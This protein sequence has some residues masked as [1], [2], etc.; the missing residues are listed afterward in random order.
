MVDPE[1]RHGLKALA[2]QWLGVE[3]T[4]IDAL[5]DKA[6]E[7]A[8]GLAGGFSAWQTDDHRDVAALFL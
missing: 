6:N 4:E 8:A 1:G 2:R 5:I 7:F 3:M